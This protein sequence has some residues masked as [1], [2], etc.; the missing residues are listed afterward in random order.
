M[1][2]APARLRGTAAGLLTAALTLAAHTLGGGQLPFGATGLQLVVAGA[3]GGLA[4]SLWVMIAAHAGATVLA[5]ALSHRGP[6]FAA[7]R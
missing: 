3:A 2:K 5:A 7:W 4:A 6:P 1:S